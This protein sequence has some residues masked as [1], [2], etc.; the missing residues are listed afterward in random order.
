MPTSCQNLS[1]LFLY[2]FEINKSPNAEDSE[3]NVLMDV[4][5]KAFNNIVLIMK[6]FNFLGID[7]VTLEA[8]FHW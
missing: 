3:V 4:I 8:D 2:I 7:W 6:D 5:K 1:Y